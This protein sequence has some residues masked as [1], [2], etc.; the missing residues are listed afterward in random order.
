MWIS[1]Q[2]QSL[3]LVSTA[4]VGCGT[5]NKYTGLTADIVKNEDR[6]VPCADGV[7]EIVY[8]NGISPN[9]QEIFTAKRSGLMKQDLLNLTNEDDSGA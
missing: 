7:K 6:P 8:Q 2:E 3:S 4:C 9:N 1:F 5:G